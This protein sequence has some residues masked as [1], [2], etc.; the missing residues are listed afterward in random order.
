MITIGEL[1]AQALMLMGINNALNISS[2]DIEG[3]KDD[4]TYGTY[5]HGMNGAINRCLSRMYTVGALEQEPALVTNLA[6]ETDT[7]VAFAPDIT[8]TLANL[9]PLY[10]VGDVFALDEPSVAQNMRNEF[11]QA[12]NDYVIKRLNNNVNSS[13]I[14]IV[15]ECD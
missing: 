6:N 5:I 9:I 4:P 10:I 14:Q 15:Y 1:K 2:G 8:K 7:I 13:E 3:L 11:E 12:L